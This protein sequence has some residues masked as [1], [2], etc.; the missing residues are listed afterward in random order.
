MTNEAHLTTQNIVQQVKEGM[1]SRS[2]TP[3]MKRLCKPLK[4]HFKINYLQYTRYFDDGIS[5]VS[6]DD[7]YT[8]YKLCHQKNTMAFQAN[9]TKLEWID[10]HD[11]ELTVELQKKF[12]YINGLSV[13]LKHKNFIEQ[14][15][16]GTSYRENPIIKEL[17][18]NQ[19]LLNL[20]LFYFKDAASDIISDA[21]N[22]KIFLNQPVI[23]SA[24]SPSSTT[25]ISDLRPKRYPIVG[26][27]GKTTLT[28]MEKN[29]LIE[30]LK[31]KTSKR[32]AMDL[33]ISAKTVEH[34]LSKLKL[35]L[36]VACKNQFYII[37]K[38][39]SLI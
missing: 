9:K 32:I 28:S 19:E 1:P 18:L 15:C 24:P 37:A 13:L 29:C 22:Y 38:N 16:L 39:N 7:N 30:T 11:P 23:K 20:V 10:Y 4:V 34:H 14:I 3:D 12:S 2:H 33:G 31:L 5:I 35:K 8:T 25:D 6:S 17:Q 21:H 27:K 36:G 26:L